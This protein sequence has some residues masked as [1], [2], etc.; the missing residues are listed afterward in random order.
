MLELWAIFSG[1]ILWT[2]LTLCINE[3]SI[4][5]LFASFIVLTLKLFLR[6][7][8]ACLRRLRNHLEN[9]LVGIPCAGLNR[10]FNDFVGFTL[11]RLYSVSALLGI[12][13]QKDYYFPPFYTRPTNRT[14][15]VTLAAN[16][17]NTRVLV[18]SSFYVA[19]TV[20][21]IDGKTDAIPIGWISSI[22]R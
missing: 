18:L 2:L 13:A 14:C 20:E 12:C 22:D 1:R 3:K 9:R 4:W 15:T 5:P 21:V 8:F 17:M 10:T 16:R 6:E 7:I 19:Y 11:Y